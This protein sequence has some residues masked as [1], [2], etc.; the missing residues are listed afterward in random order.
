M[1]DEFDPV[2]LRALMDQ[3]AAIRSKESLCSSQIE[4]LKDEV[5]KYEDW[6]QQ[7]RDYRDGNRA[8]EPEYYTKYP[9]G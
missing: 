3:E 1:T 6:L 7:W 5:E 8:T 4:D 9:N 2:R